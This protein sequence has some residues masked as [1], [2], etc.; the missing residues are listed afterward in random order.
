MESKYRFRWEA[1]S[2]VGAVFAP[3]GLLFAVIGLVIDKMAK[4]FS[5]E[6]IHTA[7]IL[8]HIF[9]GLGLLFLAVGVCM[10][11]VML[12][13]YFRIKKLVDAGKFVMADFTGAKKMEGFELNGYVPYRAQFAYKDEFGETHSFE[14]RL[15]EQDPTPLLTGK[16]IRVF[17]DPSDYG[18]YYAEIDAVEGIR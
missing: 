16:Q 5:T 12:M 8:R 14:S 11:G 7:R 10:L 6:Q 17:V 9:C 13:K 3:V 2:I 1:V 18:N 4:G 15:A